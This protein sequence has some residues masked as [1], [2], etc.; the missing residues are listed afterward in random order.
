MMKYLKDI[1]VLL[2]QHTWLARPLYILG[3]AIGISYGFYLF[4][5]SIRPR[6]IQRERF[7]LSAFVDAL[8][9]P[10]IAFIWVE[11]IAAFL[12][13]LIPQLNTTLI[14]TWIKV[15]QLADILLLG[16]GLFRFIRLF[17]DQLLIGNLTKKNIDETMVQA[18]GKLLQVLAFMIVILFLLPVFGIPVSGI[19]AFGGGSAIVV[20]I[21]AQQILANYFGGLI[22]YSERHFKVGDWI[23]SPDRNIEGIVEYIGWRATQIRTPEKRPQYVPNAVFSSIIVVNGS[24]MSHRRIRAIVSLRHADA[25]LLQGITEDIRAMLK[26]HPDIDTRQAYFAHFTE[27]GNYALN[28]EV[29]AFSRTKDKSLYYDA[30]QD[31]FLKTLEIIKQHGAELAVPNIRS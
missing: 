4:Y 26:D 25:P 22:I 10:L 21:G 15:H 18:V 23:Y 2:Q 31:I 14:P 9:W 20:G 7:L 28:L 12:D 11:A 24:R 29:T 16:W 3:I 6:L 8:E 1:Q 5:K 13:L 17:E 30:Q 27:F 19:V